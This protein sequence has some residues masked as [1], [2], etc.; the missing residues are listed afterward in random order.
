MAES[1]EGAT[2][3]GLGI[4]C[5]MHEQSMYQVCHFENKSATMCPSSY[6]IIQ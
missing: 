3:M 5:V 6:R 1:T 4:F 2:A